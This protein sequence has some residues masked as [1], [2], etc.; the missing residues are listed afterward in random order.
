MSLIDPS[1]A[2]DELGFTHPPLATYLDSI[3]ASLFAAWPTTQPPG[4][5]QRA[6]EIALL[7]RQ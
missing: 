1:R 7:R 2:I 6:A 3:L 5:D 4:Y